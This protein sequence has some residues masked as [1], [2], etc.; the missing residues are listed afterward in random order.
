MPAAKANLAKIL[1]RMNDLEHQEVEKDFIGMFFGGPGVG[2]TVASV[3]LA[4][5]LRG[6]GRAL[7]LD[8]SDGWV[9]IDN[10]PSLKRGIDRIEVS[11]P[12]DLMTIA[13]ALRSRHKGFEG[14][15]VVILD[16]VS[17]WYT[18]I[19][20]AYVREQTGTKDD[21]DL[22]EI[23]GSMHAAPQAMF[24][25]VIK[26]FHKTENL[27]VIMVAHEQ[28]RPIKG[29]SGALLMSPSLGPKI[30]S[31]LAQLSHLIARFES[32]KVKDKYER[33]AQVWPT[34]YVMA[35]SRI[36]G[37]DLKLPVASLVKAVSEWI[38]SSRMG[39]DLIKPEEKVLAEEP[40]DD[41][42]DEDFE[43]SDDDS[44]DDDKDGES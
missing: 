35:K 18:D 10:H 39:D 38:N 16:E 8:S 30:T 21:E 17:S 28:G 22:P 4:Q 34:R 25:N 37:L 13:N 29:E 36:G 27:H 44:E 3:G 40:D 23:E 41:D 5:K 42:E 9:S 6:E 19:L 12:R 26:T 1:S 31:G 24:L 7:Y 15:R 20:H 33:E 11:D 2:K 43:I 32:R 14:Y